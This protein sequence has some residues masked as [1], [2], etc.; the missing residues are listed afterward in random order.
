MVVGGV[1][2]SRATWQLAQFAKGQLVP[3]AKEKTAV[4][5]GGRY[6]TTMGVAYDWTEKLRAHSASR[7][8][9]GAVVKIC[10]RRPWI[11]DY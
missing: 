6:D 5:P 9:S 11:N 8:R 4:T 1:T 10:H 2:R 7:Y 3:S